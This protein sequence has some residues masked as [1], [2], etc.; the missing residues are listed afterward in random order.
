MSFTPSYKG[1][2]VRLVAANRGGPP[3]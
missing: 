2:A 3:E 1:I